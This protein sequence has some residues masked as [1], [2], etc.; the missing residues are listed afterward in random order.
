MG[1][2]GRSNI[3]VVTVSSSFWGIRKAGKRGESHQGQEVQRQLAQ[4]GRF[5]ADLK[6]P[7]GG[8]LNP[9]CSDRPSLAPHS[10]RKAEGRLELPHRATMSW[11]PAA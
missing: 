9:G 4:L 2:L 3:Q 7:A 5:P 10:A 11:H 6:G 8:P 1:Q